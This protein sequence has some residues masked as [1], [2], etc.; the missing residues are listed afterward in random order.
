MKKYLFLRIKVSITS[1]LTELSLSDS[2]LS[3]LLGVGSSVSLESSESETEDELTEYAEIWFKFGIYWG[4]LGFDLA[5]SDSDPDE[6]DWEDDS[7]LSDLKPSYT[8]SSKF[9]DSIFRESAVYKL[10]IVSVSRENVW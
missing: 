2:C 9:Y 1:Y 4:P 6:L 3:E 10:V 8:E 7:E 5:V